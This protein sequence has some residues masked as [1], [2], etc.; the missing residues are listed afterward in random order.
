MDNREEGLIEIY[1]RIKAKRLE[2][3]LVSFKRTPTSPSELDD[4]PCVFMTEGIDPIRK[5]SNRNAS[6]YPAQR[7]LE[8]ELEL[9]VNKTITPIKNLAM[10]LRKAVFTVKNSNPEEYSVRVAENVF[11]QENRTEGPIGYGL[12]DIEVM[13]LILNLNYIDGG[14]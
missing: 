1:E 10:D 6:G 12:P 11:I 13:R 7:V 3:G 9:V 5:H 2:L 8:V 4:L 14:F